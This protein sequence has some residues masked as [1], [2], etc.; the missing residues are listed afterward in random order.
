MAMDQEVK[1]LIFQ[2]TS[3]CNIDCQYCYLPDRTSKRRISVPVVERTIENLRDS[4][5][6]GSN[7]SIA[8]HAGEPLVVPLS[9]YRK[10]FKSIKAV[11]P[12]QVKVR[13]SIQTN[14]ILIN[15]EWCDFIK[16]NK[17]N[18]GLSIDGPGF[19]HDLYR[20]TRNGKGTFE[21]VMKGIELLKKN[22]IPFHTISVITRQ[23]LDFPEEIFNFFLDLGVR[24]IALNIEEIEGINT[25]NSHESK[26]TLTKVMEF[27]RKMHELEKKADQKIAIREFTKIRKRILN[28]Q[29]LSGGREKINDLASPLHIISVGTDGSFS[30]FSPE[31]LE[32]KDPRY[33]NFVFGNVFEDNIGDIVNKDKF[34]LIHADIEEGIRRCKAECEFY[35]LCGGGAPS[36]KL[37]ENGSFESTETLYCIFN[38]KL[39]T[40]IVLEEFEEMLENKSGV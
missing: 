18:I 30:T 24:R 38:Y 34:R 4:E 9:F 8:W 39:T 35:P 23:S 31:L 12:Q 37:Y 11:L 3:F 7:L 10:V 15:Q 33:D 20:T 17:I 26:G 32:Q 5:L 22:E 36:N 2:A 1:L 21:K 40:Q 29:L 14:G 19:I 6:L 28:R 27:M 16:E 25:S 13:H